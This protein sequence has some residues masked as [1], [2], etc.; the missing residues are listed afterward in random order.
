MVSVQVIFLFSLIP[1]NHKTNDKV[2]KELLYLKVTRPCI[3]LPRDFNI[4]A[5]S[6]LYTTSVHQN[7]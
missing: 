1:K 2:S 3:F 4:S 7:M 5:L 6:Y